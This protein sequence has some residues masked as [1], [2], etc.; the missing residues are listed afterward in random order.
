MQNQQ[1][2]YTVEVQL[3]N[4]ERLVESLIPLNLTDTDIQF[5]LDIELSRLQARYPGC[6]FQKLNI[7]ERDKKV[8][9]VSEQACDFSAIEIHAKKFDNKAYL[10][11]EMVELSVSD[12]VINRSP[13]QCGRLI[14]NSHL[15]PRFTTTANIDVDDRISICASDITIY[16]SLYCKNIEFHGGPITIREKVFAREDISYMGGLGRIKVARN[17]VLLAKRNVHLETESSIESD[18]LVFAG[19]IL[20]VKA[21]GKILNTQTGVFESKNYMSLETPSTI[22]NDNLTQALKLLV[23]TDRLVST[24]PLSSVCAS[25]KG[26]LYVRDID[27]CGSI[28]GGEVSTHSDSTRLRAGAVIDLEQGL[29]CSS[30]M[31]LDNGDLFCELKQALLYIIF[32]DEIEFGGINHTDCKNMSIILLAYLYGKRFEPEYESK[33]DEL[34]DTFQLFRFDNIRDLAS[35]PILNTY[36]IEEVSILSRN[37]LATLGDYT[38]RA[39]LLYSDFDNWYTDLESTHPAQI[40]FDKKGVISVKNLKNAGNITSFGDLIINAENEFV[41][42]VH[43]CVKAVGNCKISVETFLLNIGKIISSSDLHITAKER[44]IN[45]FSSTIE[46]KNFE[47]DTLDFDNHHNVICE[48]ARLHIHETFE[49]YLSGYITVKDA[50]DILVKNLVV[51]GR[52]ESQNRMNIHIKETHDIKSSAQLSADTHLGLNFEQDLNSLG[53][54]FLAKKHLSITTKGKASFTDEIKA[55]GNISITAKEV[56]NGDDVPNQIIS[57]K[58]LRIQAENVDNING[59]LHGDTLNIVTD[60]HLRNG[61]LVRDGNGILVPN[62]SKIISDRGAVLRSTD[63]GNL[64]NEGTLQLSQPTPSVPNTNRKAYS[65][66]LDYQGGMIHNHGGIFDFRNDVTMWH[67]LLISEME[68]V[69][70]LINPSNSYYQTR[71]TTAVPLF[72][73]NGNFTMHG[74]MRLNGC[75]F[76]VKDDLVQ[77]YSPEKLQKQGI[78]ATPMV[79]FDR[80]VD[81]E[82]IIHK[83]KRWHGMSSKR[84]VET[85][86]HHR[87]REYAKYDAK[88]HISGNFNGNDPNANYQFDTGHIG[89]IADIQFSNMQFSYQGP[90]ADPNHPAF[91]FNGETT[92]TGDKLLVENWLSSNAPM[93]IN[94][95]DLDVNQTSRVE[96][97]KAKTGFKRGTKEYL[98]AVRKLNSNSGKFTPHSL[99]ANVDNYSQYGGEVRTTEGDLKLNIRYKGKVDAGRSETVINHHSGSVKPVYTEAVFAAENGSVS[100]TGEGSAT[101]SGVN[102]SAKENVSIVLDGG[103]SLKAIVE[104]YNVVLSDKSG[105]LGINRKRHT[106]ML[107][108]VLGNTIR[109][110]KQV[111]LTSHHDN[112]LAENTTF[113][114]RGEQRPAENIEGL[115]S[116]NAKE[117]NVEITAITAQEIHR[118]HKSRLS[119]FRYTRSDVKIHKISVLPSFFLVQGNLDVHARDTANLHSVKGRVTGDGH[120]TGKKVI[121][122]GMKN[123][124]Q[125]DTKTTSFGISFFGSAAIESLLENGPTFDV[126]H[127]LLQEEPFV[128]AL[129][130]ISTAGSTAET[131]YASLDTFL[132]GYK[133]VGMVYGACNTDPIDSNPNDPRG[134][135]KDLLGQFTD[136]YGL[137]RLDPHTG[138]RSFDPKVTFD[139]K[140]IKSK[141]YDTET[142]STDLTFGGIVEIRGDEIHLIDGTKLNAHAIRLFAR[143]LINIKGTQDIHTKSMNS[144]GA[145]V[146]VNARSQSFASASASYAEGEQEGV[147]HEPAR[148]NAAQFVAEVENRE[149]G[150]MS[151]DGAVIHATES[152]SVTVNRLDIRSQ[153]NTHTASQFGVTA[154]V[155][156]TS[157]SVAGNEAQ[158][159][160]Q[161][162]KDVSGIR[163]KGAINVNVNQL[164][165]RGATLDAQGKEGITFSRTDG[166]ER[167]VDITVSNL[168]NFVRSESSG[169]GLSFGESTGLDVTASHSSSNQ[170]GTTTASILGALHGAVPNL[171]GVNRQSGNEQVMGQTQKSS[172]MLK[173][174]TLRGLAAVADDISNKFGQGNSAKGARESDEDEH[175]AADKSDTGSESNERRTSGKGEQAS[176]TNPGQ[177][178]KRGLTRVKLSNQ[179]RPDEVKS[180]QQR[181]SSKNNTSSNSY[182]ADN[183]GKRPAAGE[184]ASS[185]P[186]NRSSLRMKPVRVKIGSV[187]TPVQAQSDDSE[188]KSSTTSER[189]GE[190]MIDQTVDRLHHLGDKVNHLVGESGVAKPWLAKLA[191]GGQL[192]AVAYG[193]DYLRAY[194]DA[195]ASEGVSPGERA[196]IDVMVDIAVSSVLRA[197][198]IPIEL[199]RLVPR[200]ERERFV[201]QM[202]DQ[203]NL[204]QRESEMSSLPNFSFEMTQDLRRGQAGAYAPEAFD[205]AVRGLQEGFTEA[206]AA[207]KSFLGGRK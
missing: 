169:F 200:E 182:E 28:S 6:I 85:R 116:L 5:D 53:R 95:K 32:S 50:I 131:I 15:R 104:Y 206:Y 192:K 195:E 132:A 167:S 146:G 81:I 127:K 149:A 141:Q 158:S 20:C 46:A 13:I 9:L 114:V 63:G 112:I 38:E 198:T 136:R 194:Q 172:V 152:A 25:I 33:F 88:I 154:T 77:A 106:A 44:L 10:R 118:I 18:G 73:V 89:G 97:E 72:R 98:Q 96:Y 61:Q 202:E 66:Q 67:L 71:R 65:I 47:L 145:S 42:L 35:R 26:D 64:I 137:T 124:M 183:S 43:G 76:Y 84:K 130:S 41:N 177:G 143:D 69:E 11:S 144:V 147:T 36:C 148:L 168:D 91:I 164:N 49:N 126:I 110:G 59:T 140:T 29:L 180:S 2:V 79:D 68:A 135:A 12:A 188:Q 133:L 193:V 75:R 23:R 51:D 125:I 14:M 22:D 205:L 55:E 16:K 123:K 105:F 171:A 101:F 86:Y 92:L 151:L 100:I 103:I 160:S 102:I 87:R 109:S 129:E 201:N 78:F 119:G 184:D 203:I 165:L 115:L 111:N 70:K 39:T 186:D 159:E 80:W 19:N 17:G 8:T 54:P 142:V 74:L 94:V 189:I 1:S 4:A 156:Y 83:K 155:S 190:F 3:A 34:L 48:R 93:K 150:R 175:A 57:K 174:D 40:S 185:K 173:T 37:I 162:T 139:W 56:T 178:N 121:F 176:N 197:G 166:Q 58:R 117:G 134:E 30:S 90:F 21:G 170:G 52:L 163:S 161:V 82:T 120:I 187:K 31:Q 191:T 128:K 199:M 60:K 153:Q 108:V 24:N 179:K 99:D 204:I 62:G 113:I 181:S 207:T 27:T 138:V 45:G 7:D 122:D 157:G 196:A 107:P